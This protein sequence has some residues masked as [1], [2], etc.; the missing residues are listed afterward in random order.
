MLTVGRVVA[1]V[2]AAIG[3]SI[4]IAKAICNT[5]DAIEEAE[6]EIDRRRMI[7]DEEVSKLEK[8]KIVVT[9]VVEKAG[10]DIY[11]AVSWLSVWL[12]NAAMTG[13][14]D[15][16]QR[17]LK[18]LKDWVRKADENLVR[19]AESSIALAK[20]REEGP[21]RD[22]YTGMAIGYI[23]SADILSGKTIAGTI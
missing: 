2:G 3:G 20:E 5:V 18:I 15:R 6:K 11:V 4:A 9:K 14:K 22:I 10:S 13:L 1:L 7:E 21:V 19:G 12:S 17:E 23:D 8:A 16:N